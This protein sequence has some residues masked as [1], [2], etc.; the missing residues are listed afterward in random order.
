MNVLLGYGL[1]NEDGVRIDLDGLCDQL[2]VGD[3]GTHVD[4]VY[5]LKALQT[6]VAVEALHVHDRVDA[7]GVGV[8][9]GGCTD[10]GDGAADVLRDPF[11]AFYAVE[12]VGFYLRNADLGVVHRVVNGAVDYEEGVADAQVA[13]VGHGGFVHAHQLRVLAGSFLRFFAVG[14]GQG[15]AHLNFPVVVG[16]AVRLD[17]GKIDGA[18]S[19]R[20]VTHY[21]APPSIFS[22][23][24]LK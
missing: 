20:E 10:H 12:Y 16:I 13:V 19:S 24:G 11:T 7:Y 21:L 5:V 22:I 2:F 18:C 9:T 14:Y 8:G 23:N 15:K 17:L 6:E 4:G 3:L 1:G